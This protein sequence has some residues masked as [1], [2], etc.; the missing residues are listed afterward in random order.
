VKHFVAIVL[1]SLACTPAEDLDAPWRADEM[2]LMQSLT[3]PP[4][5]APP[6]PGNRFADDPRAAALGQKLFFDKRLSANGEIAC[7]TCHDPAK[8]FSDGRKVGQGIQKA[9]RNT[10][11]LLGAQ[12]FPFLFHDGRK[13]SLWSQA[14]GPLERAGEMGFD[15]TALAHHVAKFYRAEY[16]AVFGPL[17]SFDDAHRFPP[18]A[19]PVPLES[20]HPQQLAWNAMAPADRAEVER[21]FVHCGKAIEAYER[22]LLAGPAP[23]DQ[24]VAAIQRGDPK[25]GGHLSD[26]AR[27]GLRLFIGR[28]Q[29]VNCHNGPLFSDFAFHN[30]GLPRSP[31]VT[32]VDVGRTLGAKQVKE[33]PFRCG[34]PHSDAPNGSRACDELRFLDPRFEDFLGAFK[35]P[36]LRNVARTAPYMHAGQFATL[37]EVIAFYKS[38]PGQAQ[39]G[40]RELILQLLPNDVPT[41]ALVAFLESLTGTMPDARW[42]TK[43]PEVP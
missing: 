14:L 42:L 33:D 2:T 30:L 1:V 23:F 38:Q 20:Q 3:P 13:D 24:Y 12:F 16:E 9:N 36:T 10:P 21:V 18:H 11:T 6:S 4:T 8:A 26:D 43:P 35:T 7:A 27:R 19:R 34:G 41:E 32:G 5:V 39:L 29:C 15:R 40:H 31:E 28:A 17:P 22:H 25:G 37:A